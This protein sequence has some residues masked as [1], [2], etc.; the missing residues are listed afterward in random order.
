ML[1]GNYELVVELSNG[2]STTSESLMG[3]AGPAGAQGATGPVGA[4]GA[5]GPEGPVGAQGPEGETGAPGI[6]G[7]NGVDGLSGVNAL[8]HVGAE[9]A[10]SN[11]TNGGVVIQGG[12]DFNGD[13]ILQSLETTT[14]QYVCN[15]EDAESPEVPEENFGLPSFDDS[16]PGL[17][18][19][20]ILGGT[21]FDT[22]LG[23]SRT[24]DGQLWVPDSS[25]CG[26]QTVDSGEQCDSGDLTLDDAVLSG[27][28][29]AACVSISTETCSQ[30][31][32]DEG[33]VTQASS[34][35][36][37]G[38]G[39]ADK[40]GYALSLSGD[41]LAVGEHLSDCCGT[42]GGGVWVYIKTGNSWVLEDLVNAVNK[43]SND[44]FGYAVSIEGETLLVGSPNEDSSA[45]NAGSAYVFNRSGGTWTQQKQLLASDGNQYDNL[46]R[47]VSLSGE[48]AALG[49]PMADPL[50]A[51]SGAV[52]VYHRAGS[53]WVAGSKIV[54]LDGGSE[55]YFGGAVSLSGDTLAIG[56]MGDGDNGMESGSVYIYTRSGQSWSLEQKIIAF[57]GVL[58]DSFGTSVSVDGDTLAVGATGDDETSQDTGS[59]YIYN[60]ENGVW[61]FVQKLNDAT[62]VGDAFGT[63]LSVS[64]N[65]LVVGAPKDEVSVATSGA[66]YVYVYTGTN[67]LLKHKVEAPDAVSDTDYGISVSVDGT[68][69]AIGAPGKT[70][71]KG[72]AYLNAMGTLCTADG[73]CICQFGYG[74]PECSLNLNTD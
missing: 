13:G 32:S 43:G 53:D 70:N 58:Q 10:G 63:S 9:P 55:E 72:N 29:C 33:T 26:D 25:T 42:N 62:D 34:I 12:Q 73:N 44:W 46:G 38:D 15:G 24:C 54:P 57:D 74:G 66:A 28:D 67:W 41:L 30:T 36:I 3:P 40:F 5:M 4:Q 65:Q 50:G 19:V 7:L 18:D 23:I 22:I 52:Y 71:S 64:G 37:P 47:A 59:V 8:V 2:V 60:R 21:Y 69:Y 1:N 61:S 45:S 35:Q 39:T 31:C 56:A 48:T 17:C 6:S 49:A 27:S 11:C 14:A 51:D 68:N 20:S 16:P